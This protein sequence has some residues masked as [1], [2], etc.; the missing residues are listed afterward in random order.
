MVVGRHTIVL[1]FSMSHHISEAYKSEFPFSPNN[2]GLPLA[3]VFAIWLL[4][5]TL[6]YFPCRWF[7]QYKKTHDY[8]WLTY[9]SVPG[10]S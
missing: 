5:I 3:G 6:L 1:F 2:F 4:L 9:L 8:W 7:G 10:K